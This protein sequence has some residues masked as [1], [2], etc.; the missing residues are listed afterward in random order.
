MEKIPETV[1]A[2]KIEAQMPD[3]SM[4]TPE[5]QEI[6]KKRWLRKMEKTKKKSKSALKK[7]DTTK[8]AFETMKI[9]CSLDEDAI[10][11][12]HTALY[13]SK[14]MNPA[15]NKF[16]KPR[17]YEVGELCDLLKELNV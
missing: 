14:K 9:R 12:K 10:I 3:F 6:K 2:V 8:G 11:K 4:F 1:D 7:G 17:S 16:Y 15:P 5:Q 13:G